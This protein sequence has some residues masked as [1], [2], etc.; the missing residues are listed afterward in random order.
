M[1]HHPQTRRFTLHLADGRVFHGAE[2]PSGHAAVNH[3]DDPVLPSVFT[4]TLGIEHLTDVPAG[5]PLHGA[6]LEWTDPE[7]EQRAETAEAVLAR[8]RAV[9]VPA[10]QAARAKVAP[11]AFD[12][13]LCQALGG[14]ATEATDPGEQ[15]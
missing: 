11:T 6:R 10:C 7:E 12:C 15:P 5:H 4:V 1:T 3:P 9:H 14:A 2:F 8:V 13:P